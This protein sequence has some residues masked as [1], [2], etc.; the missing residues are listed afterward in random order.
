MSRMVKT[1]AVAAAAAAL[2]SGAAGTALADSEAKGVAA[3]SSGTGSGNVLQI[4]INFPINFCG[5]T[6]DDGSLFN[7]A[8][9]NVCA[10]GGLDHERHR[11]DARSNNK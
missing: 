4:P 11:Y 8:I 2:V 9:G 10:H 5:N 7:P 1:C 3:L 6:I